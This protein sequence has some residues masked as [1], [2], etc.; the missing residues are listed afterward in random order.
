MCPN[1]PFFQDQP[2]PTEEELQE[3]YYEL[4]EAADPYA[5]GM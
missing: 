2:P 3:G 1:Y 5:G 4:R